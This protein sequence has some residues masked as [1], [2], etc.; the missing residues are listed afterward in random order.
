M[1]EPC[2]A[3]KRSIF[4]SKTFKN[5]R[6]EL[7]LVA[8]L[9]RLEGDVLPPGAAGLP[10]DGA[11]VRAA[12]SVWFAR[13]QELVMSTGRAL[14]LLNCISIVSIYSHTICVL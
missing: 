8:V 14:S 6:F 10:R 5:H 1:F 11:T 12:W 2:F 9:R 13:N 3:S 4:P 7:V